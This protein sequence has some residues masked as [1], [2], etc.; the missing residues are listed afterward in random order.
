MTNFRFD[1]INTVRKMSNQTSNEPPMDSSSSCKG[2]RGKLGFLHEMSIEGQFG[3]LQ[4]KL[5]IPTRYISR[6]LDT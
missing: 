2:Q 5:G 1:S 6:Y 4:S 3:F